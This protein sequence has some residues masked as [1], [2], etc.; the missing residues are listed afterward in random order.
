M[1]SNSAAR[2]ARIAYGV[3]AGIVWVVFVVGNLLAWEYFKPP[4]GFSLKGPRVQKSRGEAPTQERLQEEDG[5]EK[6]V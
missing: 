5:Y 4:T 1:F 3:I 2:G 6:R